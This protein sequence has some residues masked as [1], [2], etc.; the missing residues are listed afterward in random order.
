MSSEKVSRDSDSD[1][2][3]CHCDTINNRRWLAVNTVRD[4]AADDDLAANFRVATYN[5][6]SDNYLLDGKYSY[7]P[8][9]L[10]YMSSRHQR[11]IDEIHA[12][13]PHVVCFQVCLS[14]HIGFDLGT[15]FLDDAST[16]HWS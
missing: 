11:I 14:S 4:D 6:L 13:Q 3:V 10:R 2:G 16:Q 12:M 9:Q 8:S 1:S 7:C 5:I 15:S